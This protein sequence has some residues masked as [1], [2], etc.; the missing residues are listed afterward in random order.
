M[1]VLVIELRLTACEARAL[2]A[3][4]CFFPK[5]GIFSKSQ[6]TLF[7]LLLSSRPAKCHRMTGRTITMNVTQ[8]LY[9]IWSCHVP[10]ILYS[11]KNV[12]Y[13]PNIP[14]L[15]HLSWIILVSRKVMRR[16]GGIEEEPPLLKEPLKGLRFVCQIPFT[17]GK[18]LSEENMSVSEGARGRRRS[19]MHT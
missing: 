3:V 10:F 14:C 18:R 11:G 4:L 2:P 16:V 9:Q 12:H 1:G 6:S 8:A 19:D 7:L 15:F 13:C 5:T 17:D